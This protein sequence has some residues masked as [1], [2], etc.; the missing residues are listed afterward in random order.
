M[1]SPWLIQTCGSRVI[2][3]AGRPSDWFDTHLLPHLTPNVCQSPLTIEAHRFQSAVSKH[4]GNLSVLLSVFPE[5][6]FALVI[7]VLVLS[8]SAIF[9][10][11]INCPGDP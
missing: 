11:L 1:I 4:L 7:L 8:S 9:T 10:T 2:K 3:L 6:K 5:N